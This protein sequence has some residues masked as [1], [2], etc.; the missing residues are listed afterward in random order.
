M[1][2]LTKEE[3]EH[4][5]SHMKWACD[6]EVTE[7][8]IALKD[9]IQSMIDNYCEHEWVF[10]MSPRGNIVRCNKCNRGLNDNQ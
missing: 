8:N 5:Y 2:D 3:L 7:K 10:Y 6:I 9:K 1:N 4:L